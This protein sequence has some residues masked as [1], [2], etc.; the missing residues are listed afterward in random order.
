DVLR[1]SAEGLSARRM[2]VSLAIG[3]TTLLG[4]LER[5]QEAG[6]NWPLPPEMADAELERLL[7][8]C[9]TILLFASGLEPVAP[10][11]AHCSRGLANQKTKRRPRVLS[12]WSNAG[13]W[14]GCTAC[15]S[16]A[17]RK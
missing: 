6:L 11:L 7:Y 13:S 16:S 1:L 17:S 12:C 9:T 3:R 10:S 8:P 15:N 14:R 2:A 5:E 4:Y